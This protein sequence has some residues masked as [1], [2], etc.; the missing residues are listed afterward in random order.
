MKIIRVFWFLIFLCAVTLALTKSTVVI[1]TPEDKAHL[2]TRTIE[3]DYLGWTLNAVGIKT[4]EAGIGVTEKLTLFQKHQVVVR[5]FDLVR[6]LES[7]TGKVQAI[8]SDPSV[9]NPQLT[10]KDDLTQQEALQA[11]LGRLDPIVEDI[12]QQQ[13]AETVIKLGIARIGEV[14]PPVLYHTS[15]TPKSLIT[16]PRNKIEQDVSISLMADLTLAETSQ[17][18]AQVEEKTGESALVV[19][20]G[21][22]GV[23]PTMVMRTSDLPWVVNTIAHEWTHNYLTMRSLGLNYDT[24][25]QLRIMNETTAS[26]AGNE[27][28]ALVLKTYYPELSDNL[29]RSSKA[30]APVKADT[31]NF[32]VEMH[33]TRVTV[34][35]LLAQG[36]VNEAEQYMEQ[37]RQVF[38][39]HG[40]LIRKLNQAYFAFYGAYADS[41]VSA[42]GEDPVGEA[43]RELRANSPTLAVFLRKIAWMN[44]YEDL[45]KAVGK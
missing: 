18:E 15:A 25:P 36:K 45:Q 23:Y 30:A 38:V 41:P 32:Q 43:V 9:K 24:T 4:G 2:Y 7:V 42:A 19:G 1:A 10:A 33:Q 6:Q 16:S 17:L 39:D 22:I 28:G 35:D 44:S 27:I 3:F 21:G 31:F 14:L 5:Y 12:L 11:A 29:G 20:T 8:Y 37:R 26:I 34:D 13:V 40:Y